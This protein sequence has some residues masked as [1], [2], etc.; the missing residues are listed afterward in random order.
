MAYA[1][2]EF[3]NSDVRR[4]G[5][6]LRLNDVRASDFEWANNVL[7]NWRASHAYPLNTFQSTLRRKLRRID[8]EE[9]R[10]GFVRNTAESALS[11]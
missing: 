6:I 5:A 1:R 9:G 11:F 10:Q 2:P 4:A 7:T 8:K 3:L